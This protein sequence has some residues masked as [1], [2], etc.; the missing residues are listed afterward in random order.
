MPKPFLFALVLAL[1]PVPAAAASAANS[2]PPNVNII[3]ETRGVIAYRALESSQLRGEERF[4]ISVHPDGSRTLSTISRYGPPDVQRHSL[5]RIDADL[6][7]MDATVQ[8]WIDGAWR[9]SGQ[10]TVDGNTL[11]ASSRTPRGNDTHALA[12][13]QNFAIL[14][15]QL[16]PDTWRLLLYNASAKNVQPLALYD[17]DP[18]AEG[19][20][21]IL[22]KWTTQR[23]A[24][25]GK[26]T[27]T[28]PAG[29]FETDHYRVE[30]AVDIYVT[31]PDAVLV[32]WRFDAIDRE[33]VL[34]ELEQS[35]NE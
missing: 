9:A 15:H 4:H 22:G 5:Y 10:I 32:K 33:H 16:A 14:A 8:L 18:R 11:T 13:D 21:G 6:R 19:T 20:S 30:D 1:A 29:T 27:V 12:I 2:L 24:H 26:T 28:V 34:I 23:V 35:S 31:G 17:L 25:Q 7:P 3:R